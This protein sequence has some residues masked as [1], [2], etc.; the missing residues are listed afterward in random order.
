MLFE[1]RTV[2][3]LLRVDIVDV[4][5]TVRTG[6]QQAWKLTNPVGDREKYI[7]YYTG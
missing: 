2:P 5:I 4:K 7:C 1:Q 6:H 3:S